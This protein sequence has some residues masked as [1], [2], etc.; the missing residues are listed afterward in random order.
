MATQRVTTPGFASADEAVASLGAVQAQ[1][2]YGVRWSLGMRVQGAI[3]RDIDDA[4]NAGRIVRLHILR[5]TWHYVAP[6]DLRWM[7]Q[8]SAPRVHIVNGSLYRSQ[9]LDAALLVRACEIITAALEGGNHLTR[10]ELA[11]RLERAG[12]SAASV[13]LA[14]IIMY[15]ELEGLICSGAMRGK[16]HTYALVDERVPPAP[17]ISDEEAY[18]RLLRRYFLAHGPA[19]LDDYTRWSGMTK[20]AARRALHEIADE[21]ES[22]EI[23]GLVF[24]SDP[25]APGIQPSATAAWLIPEYDE[26]IIYRDSTLV[27]FPWMR[28]R[29]TWDDTLYRP[30]IIDGKRAGTWRRE[31]ETRRIDFQAQLFTSLTEEQRAALD[32]A[33]QRYAAFMELPTELREI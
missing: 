6:K 23:G 21:L 19:T 10:T 30:L 28:D 31:I 29:A 27:D 7:L 32:A 12:I 15:A 18:I 22:E 4:Y 33:V 3:G 16:Q 1:E 14:Y 11:D 13:R 17:T 26:T 9:G 5:P 8:I 25:A 2:F 20:T 24:Y